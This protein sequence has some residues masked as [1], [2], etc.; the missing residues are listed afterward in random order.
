MI[1]ATLKAVVHKCTNHVELVYLKAKKNELERFKRT[2]EARIEDL[3]SRKH[4]IENKAV[5]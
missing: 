4:I 2:L 5:Q 1:L 3:K